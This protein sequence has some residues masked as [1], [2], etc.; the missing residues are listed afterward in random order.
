[1]HL[2]VLALFVGGMKLTDFGLARMFGS[3]EAGKYTNQ[4]PFFPESSPAVLMLM[5]VV[6]MWSETQDKTGLGCSVFGTARH[7]HGLRAKAVCRSNNA[8]LHTLIILGAACRCLHGG[9]GPQSSCLGAH[10][11]G[12]PAICGLQD[13]SLQVTHT[14]LAEDACRRLRAAMQLPAFRH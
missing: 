4:V 2:R 9:T 8:T 11:T 7:I 12:R 14:S 13:A 1:M 3:P 5:N 6:C 10:A